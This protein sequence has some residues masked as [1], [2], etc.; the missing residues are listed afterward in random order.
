MKLPD[1]HHINPDEYYLFVDTWKQEWEKGVQV[2]A[3]PETIP[4]PSL[5]FFFYMSAL[6]KHIIFVLP[7]QSNINIQSYYPMMVSAAIYSIL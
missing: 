3:S 1:S 4:K 6:L 7:S 2:P 5:R